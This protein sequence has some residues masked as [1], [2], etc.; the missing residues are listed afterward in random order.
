MSLLQFIFSEQHS[1]RI[2]RHVTF[3]LV[4]ALHI[5]FF[6]FYVFDL[7]YLSYA[8]TYIIRFKDLLLFLPVSVFYAY[9]A[10]Y[11]LLPR[12][13]LKEKYGRLLI[14]ILFSSVLLVALSAWLS[15]LFDVKLAWD[16]PLSRASIVRKIDFT[17][18]NGLVF[19][20]MVSGFAIGIKMSKNFYLQQ[21]QNELLAK[22]KIN[23]EVQLL[24]S[25]VHPRFLF[26]S[27]N[28]IHKD[29]LNGSGQSPEMLLKL[30]DLLSYILYES[31][32]PIPLDKELLLLRN[33][34]DLEKISWGKRLTANIQN[35][36]VTGNR[37]IEP[38]LLL[39]LADFAFEI[40]DKNRQQQ[41]L[42][43]VNMTMKK[44]NFQFILSICG[45]SAIFSKTIEENIQLL[46]VQKRLQAQYNGRHVFNVT[47]DK[48]TITISLGLTLDEMIEKP[49]MFYTDDA[50]SKE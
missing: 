40:F 20:L 5:F 30:S 7:K 19:P 49:L 8:S 1:H 37:Y 38:L 13:I 50:I 16:M 45:E 11:F 34:I 23:A 36:I 15:I 14:I 39:P 9:F 17:V 29:M 32:E 22:Q 46:Q 44:P 25:Q 6:R 33:Y 26:N 2:M 47:S 12:Y 21:K 10:I 42:L 48:N 24:K 41:I 28:S 18:H 4:L 3:W 43:M 35:N 31:D 27:L